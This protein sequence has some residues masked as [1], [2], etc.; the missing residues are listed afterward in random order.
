[1]MNA[2]F[3]VTIGLVL[4]T[5]G[6]CLLGQEKKPDEE[7]FQKLMQSAGGTVGEIK[8]NIEG[9]LPAVAVSAK[10]LN[11]IFDQVQSFWINRDLEE[12]EEWS[13]DVMDA[14]DALA[15]AASSGDKA[16]AQAAFKTAT[17][18]CGQCHNT[19]R[20]KDPNGGYRIRAQ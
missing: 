2:K 11:E 3:L 16:A 1:M 10:K 14:A 7:A 4:A 13:G 20:E 15:E 19:Y 12:P 8:K 18:V 6:V 17:G 9:D 5:L